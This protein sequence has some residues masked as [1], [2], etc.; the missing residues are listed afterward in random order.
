MILQ[1]LKTGLFSLGVMGSATVLQAAENGGSAYPDGTESFMGGAMPPP[2]MYLLSYNQAE[3]NS[4]ALL[5]DFKAKA[6]S[7]DPQVRY[8]FANG[9]AIAAKYQKNSRSKIDLKDKNYPWIS[10]S[11]FNV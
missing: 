6:I 3:S 9:I 4:G 11:H 7:I 5:G 8:Q 2:G 10:P 1:H